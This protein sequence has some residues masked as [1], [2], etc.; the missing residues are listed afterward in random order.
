MIK[1]SDGLSIM[2]SA[3]ISCNNRGGTILITRLVSSLVGDWANTVEPDPGSTKDI[4]AAKWRLQNFDVCTL[5]ISLASL[6]EWA[7]NERSLKALIT[8]HG[9]PKKV[10]DWKFHD[11]VRIDLFFCDGDNIDQTILEYLQW[12]VRNVDYLVNQPTICLKSI[13]QKIERVLS[14]LLLA[15]N[16]HEVLTGKGSRV[17]M[18]I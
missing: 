11:F 2:N 7:R 15:I 1:Q 18:M 10:F 16:F 4:L 8:W 9:R 5:V 17:L 12:S 6:Q 3:I 13:V 14:G